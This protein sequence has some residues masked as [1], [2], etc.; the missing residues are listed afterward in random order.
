M[1]TTMDIDRILNENFGLQSLRPKQKEV[2]DL[3][4][5]G[6]HT[7]ALLPTGYGKSLC[8]QLP[9][10]ALPGITLVISP[11]IAFRCKIK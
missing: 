2:I 7:L 9:S 8:Y 4:L 3:V 10:M 11:L 6:K 5:R 1:H